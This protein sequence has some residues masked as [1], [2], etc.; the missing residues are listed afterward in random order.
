M[1]K[2]ISRLRS[3]FNKVELTKCFD[4]LH[5]APERGEISIISQ[6]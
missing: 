6:K 1:A 4:L 2:N 5:F 3:L